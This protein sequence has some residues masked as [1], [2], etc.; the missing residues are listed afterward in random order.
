MQLYNN[1]FYGD[2]SPNNSRLISAK[3]ILKIY[4]DIFE[5]KKIIDIGCGRGSWLE[6]SKIYGSDQLV[7]IDGE[8]NVKKVPNGIE[9]I[10]LNLQ[11]LN[12]KF[13]IDNNLENK[14]DLCISVETLEHLENKYSENFISSLCSLSN[15][16]IFSCAYIGQGGVN[17]LNENLHSNWAFIFKKYDFYPFDIFRPIV[18][19]NDK[20][21]YWYRQNTFLYLKK[22]SPS[23]DYMIKKMP[24]IKNFS[25]MDCIHPKMYEKKISKGVK[26]TFK[27]LLIKLKKKFIK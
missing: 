1:N 14:F 20:I 19:N 22:N 26:E 10:P 23:F 16:I 15:N 25:F 8:W 24:Y 5:S 9:Y 27:D 11:N 12:K 2:Q 21:S 4:F 13:I 17:H 7:G 18:W 6:A 3:E